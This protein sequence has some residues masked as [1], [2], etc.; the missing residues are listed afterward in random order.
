ML[1]ITLASGQV[2]EV[3]FDQTSTLTVTNQGFVDGVPT[4]VTAS[5]SEIEDLAIV[6]DPVPDQ[7]VIQTEDPTPPPAPTGSVPVN[8]TAAGPDATSSGAE[9]TVTVTDAPEGD[10]VT[11]DTSGGVDTSAAAP[12]AD[13][14][15][16]GSGDPIDAA[17]DVVVPADAPADVVP[18][19]TSNPQV[20]ALTDAGTPPDTVGAAL[21]AADADSTPPATGDPGDETPEPTDTTV[22]DPPP[23]LEDAV[24]AAGA[25]VDA[26]VTDPAAH[27]DHL[28]QAQT[29][30]ATALQTWPDDANLLDL[31][32]QLDDLAADASEAAAS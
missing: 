13:A 29:D 27:I 18:P 1:K 30:I 19:D 21:A 12:G 26:A 23:G 25:V 10:V 22:T 11:P 4:P 32:Q 8:T 20:D 6:A 17:A 3:P 9:T 24:A 14:P 28:V 31:K 15:V 5:F 2:Q 16:D 7:T